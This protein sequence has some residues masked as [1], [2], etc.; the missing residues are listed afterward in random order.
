MS[1]TPLYINRARI[2]WLGLFSFSHKFINPHIH[3]E[4]GIPIPQNYAQLTFALNL[5]EQIDNN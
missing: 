3:N 1:E 5:G 2:V 4:A